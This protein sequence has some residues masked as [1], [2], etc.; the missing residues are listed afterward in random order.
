MNI[1]QE[2]QDTLLHLLINP[3]GWSDEVIRDA[4]QKAANELERLWKQERT[5]KLIA[6]NIGGALA[7]R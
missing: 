6:L 4:R 3:D 5:M 7:A 1:K 2:D